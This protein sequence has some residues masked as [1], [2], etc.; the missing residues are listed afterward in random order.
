MS[1]SLRVR[2]WLGVL[3]AA[4]LAAP[5]LLYAHIRL[6]AS[7]PAHGAVLT[8][9]PSQLRLTFSERIERRYTRITLTAPDGAAVPLGPVTFVATS[10]REISVRVP[11]LPAS[12]T[13]TVGWSTAGA[14]GHVLEGSYA[15]TVAPDDTQVA[16]PG[17][18]P[19]P[20]EEHAHEAPR[21]VQSTSG[22]IGRGAHFLALLV[23]LG[24]VAFRVLLLPRLHLAPATAAALELRTWRAV[25]AGAVLL[26][27]AAVLR[28]WLQSIALHGPERA[29]SPA[30][31]SIML[32]DTAW[33]RAWLLQAFLFAALGM[34]IAWARPG[35]DRRALL[36]A[37]PTAVLLAA[38]PGLTGHAAGATGFGRLAVVN[39]AIHVAAV[40]TWLGTLAILLLVAIPAMRR[41]EAA[42][43][44]TA[45]DAV[46]TFSPLALLA[47]F[48]VAGTGVINTWMHIALPA[49]LW[50]TPYGRTLL[51]K[52]ALVVAILATGFVN[53]RV[54]RPRLRDV[55]DLRRL[56][57]SAGA[58]LALAVLILAVTAIL[59]GRP[60]P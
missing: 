30:L 36:I 19:I 22:A 37:L 13:Y 59:T 27:A 15:F 57:L 26:A 52:L 8:G 2:A 9:P 58:E 51:L 54:V 23:L 32:R 14:D 12:G 33:G 45:A 6:E 46:N 28:L 24:A 60:R 53:W 35:R 48:V 42:P 7:V 20:H 3:L 56:R 21:T 29:W 17:E 31:L 55:P 1:G 34:A 44:R 50:T 39:D 25:A 16:P 49:Q 41:F 4:S 38:I 40:G 5:A 10:D 43:E 18:P 11:P 47:A